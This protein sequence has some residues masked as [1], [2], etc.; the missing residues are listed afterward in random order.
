MG[1]FRQKSA[2]LRHRTKSRKNSLSFRNDGKSARGT[3]EKRK[4]IFPY[5]EGSQVDWAAHAN[6]PIAIITEFLAFD[7]AVGKVMD[8]AKQ[9]GETAVVVLSDHGNSGFTIGSSRCPG[10]DKLSIDKLFSAVTKYKLSANGLE[11]ILVNTKPANIKSEFKKYTDID[12]TDEEVETLLS[13]KNYKESDYTKV[14]SSEN[15]VRHIVDILVSRTCF[16]FTTGGHTGEEVLFE[17]SSAGRHSERTCD[18]YR[19]KQIST[20]SK[21]IGQTI[22][23]AY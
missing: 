14:G 3:F 8:F 4:W 23:G 21:R 6:D 5:V 19:R 15:M 11:S 9:N 17:L 1:T 18:E 20:A 13:S 12:L 10:Y 7:E 16:G 22:I 2:A